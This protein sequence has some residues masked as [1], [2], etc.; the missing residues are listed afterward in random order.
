M[1]CERVKPTYLIKHKNMEKNNA[2]RVE[3]DRFRMLFFNLH[4][5]K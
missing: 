4:Q 3:I 1:A 2:H 5:F